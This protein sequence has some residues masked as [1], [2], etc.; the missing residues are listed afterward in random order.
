[1]HPHVKWVCSDLASVFADLS[2]TIVPDK[3]RVIN[4][5]LLLPSS[6]YL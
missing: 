1:M 6:G 5:T 4:P 2:G 3:I